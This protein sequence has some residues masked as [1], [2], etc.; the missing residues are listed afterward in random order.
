M[1]QPLPLSSNQPSDESS[2]QTQDLQ[3][4]G[5]SGCPP[6]AQELLVPPPDGAQPTFHPAPC[7]GFVPDGPYKDCIRFILAKERIGFMDFL[8]YAARQR[9]QIDSSNVLI[10]EADKG[11]STLRQYNS[12]FR[13]FASF[14]RDQKPSHMST[15]LAIT[16][17]RLLSESDLA[18]NTITSAKSVLHKI[19]YYGFDFNLNDPMFSSFSRACS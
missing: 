8:T 3:G 19:F 12:T 6:V 7:P 16:Y 18:P 11:P 2:P 5:G 9:F 14:I 17:F 10:T 1:G 15:H 13:H 4:Q